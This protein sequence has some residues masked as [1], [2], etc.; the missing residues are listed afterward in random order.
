M[1][2]QSSRTVEQIF[3]QGGILIHSLP[4]EKKEAL[5]VRL[6]AILQKRSSSPCSF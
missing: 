1:N 2:V 5:L 4:K 3:A 6:Q